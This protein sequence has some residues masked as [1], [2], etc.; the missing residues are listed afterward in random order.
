VPLLV[1]EPPNPGII[2]YET[3]GRG[4]PVLFLHG[5]LGSWQLWRSTI[6]EIGKEFK[7]YSVDFWG[8]G[9]SRGAG[10]NAKN[11]QT[12]RVD[13]FVEMVNQFM[14]KLGIPKAA[15]IGHSMGGTVALSTAIKYPEKVVKTCCIGS[16]IDGN[17]LNLL[18]KLS[19]VPAFAFII[20]RSPALLKIFLRIYSRLMAADGKRM[21]KM[22]SEDISKTTMES[23]FQSIGTLRN[24]N[25]TPELDRITMPALGV[26]GK[27]DIIVR[28]QQRHVLEA[29]VPHSDIVYYPNAGHF[30]MLDVEADFISVIRDFL[31]GNLDPAAHGLP[32]NSK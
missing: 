1:T 19:G 18:L 10:E 30:P 13:S 16:P 26:F 23:F 24:T 15:I 20:W 29:G 32:S 25:L 21:A 8:F 4:R 5:W 14:E 31:K 28:P 6:E 27:K 7:T 12:F 11:L 17:S 9:D 2:H 3:H 22:I